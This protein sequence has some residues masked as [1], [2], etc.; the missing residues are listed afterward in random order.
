VSISLGCS[1]IFL[2]GGRTKNEAPLGFLV[3]SGD[4]VV[5][6]GE[7]RVCFHGVPRIIDR[8][9]QS[10][11]FTD[12]GEQAE[13]HPDGKRRKEAATKE[14]PKDQ[15][16]TKSTEWSPEQAVAALRQRPS[17]SDSPQP[18]F[19]FPSVI[20]SEV[21][22]RDELLTTYR[23]L[24]HARL[25][26]NVRQVEDELFQYRRGMTSGSAR[27]MAIEEQQQRAKESTMES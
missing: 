20:G 23:F 6:G 10:G 11:A 22:S 24:R 25:N 9:F 16:A 15:T 7:S 4:V 3:R 21:P 1:A 17:S 12:E 8:T 27:L 19:D 13:Q 14:E 18:V 2:L 5:M 26:L